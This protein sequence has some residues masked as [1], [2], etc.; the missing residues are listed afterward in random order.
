MDAVTELLGC[1]R[2]RTAMVLQ[3]FLVDVSLATSRTTVRPETRCLKIETNIIDEHITVCVIKPHPFIN[4]RYGEFKTITY[5]LQQV[6]IVTVVMRTLIVK[7]SDLYFN[8]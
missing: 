2:F 8:S 3:L 6:Q 7:L 1:V 4:T 5:P